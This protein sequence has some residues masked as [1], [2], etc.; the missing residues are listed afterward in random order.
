MRMRT[1]ICSKEIIKHAT[2]RLSSEVFIPLYVNVAMILEIPSQRETAT[3]GSRHIILRMELKESG[4][5]IQST[6]DCQNR[7]FEDTISAQSYIMHFRN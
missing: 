1:A 3:L 6:R 2:N 5:R 4:F 7:E